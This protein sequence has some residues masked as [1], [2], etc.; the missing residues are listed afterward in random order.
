MRSTISGPF[1]YVPAPPVGVMKMSPRTAPGLELRI[2]SGGG[3]VGAAKAGGRR[4]R[5]RQ[6]NES[7]RGQPGKAPTV[8]AVVRA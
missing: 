8:R 2:V 6:C 3:A 5:Y 7:E 4:Y 1:A